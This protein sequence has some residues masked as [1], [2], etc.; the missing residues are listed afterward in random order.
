MRSKYKKLGPYIEEVV[1]KNTDLG[2]KNLLGV[3]IQKKFIPSIANTVGTNMANYKIVK[4]NQFAYGPVTSRNGDKISIALLQDEEDAIIS[5]SYKVFKIVD[6]SELLP[7]YLMMWFRRPEFD[8]FA[9]FMSHGSTRETFDWEEMCDV[10]LPIPSRE[11]Q[12]EIVDEYNTV[13]ERKELNKKINKKLEET[14]QALYKH[15]FVDFEFPDEN[16]NPYKSS[17]GKMK[18]SE[19][20]GKA[21][22]SKWKDGKVSELGKVVGGATPKTSHGEYWSEHGI[23]WLSPSYLSTT[24]L[25]FIHHGER[26]ISEEGYKNSSTKML[27]KG[28][29]LFS[30]R[31]PIGLTAITEKDLCTNQGFKSVIPLSSIGTAFVYYFLAYNVPYIAGEN[32]GSTFSEV[33]G[34]DMKNYPAIL[35]AQTISQRFGILCEKV[36]ESQRLIEQENLNVAKIRSMLLERVSVV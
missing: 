32:T 27:P 16:G 19:A 35:P 4:R 13:V 7:E 12:Q 34:E 21:I 24:R 30:S 33:S 31:A 15:W 22:P 20:L 23:A 11:K 8:R 25:K 2:V 28:S 36:F 1:L 26:D 17:G 9:R 10:E 6:E 3:S 5:Q 29:V 14:A 18:Y